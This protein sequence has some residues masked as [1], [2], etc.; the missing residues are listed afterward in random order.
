MD[1]AGLTP[2]TTNPFPA[3]SA[4][5]GKDVAL[6]VNKGTDGRA[7]RGMWLLVARR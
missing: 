3:Q 7:R 2:L 5:A 4:A 6:A 1:S